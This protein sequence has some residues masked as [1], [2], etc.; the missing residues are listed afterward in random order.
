VFGRSRRL[1][2]FWN[3]FSNCFKPRLLLRAYAHD[4]MIQK[5]QT[6]FKSLTLLR[7]APAVLGI[8]FILSACAAQ[9]QR[10][11][12]PDFTLVDIKGNKFSLKDLR[13]KVVLLDFWA[14]WCPPCVIS[15]PEVEKISQ[16][17]KGKK[18]EV[19]RI[20]LD[21]SPDAVLRYLSTHSL[22]G[23]IAMTDGEVEQVYRVQGIPS[24]YMIDQTG[25][26]VKSWGGY[27]PMMPK[28][29]RQEID[30]LLN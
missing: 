8:F 12:A 19:V 7:L 29:W 14:T 23:R 3:A 5:S 2:P 6:L 18:F 25:G 24:F 11:S 10:Q 1:S 16:E 17:Y 26:L 28:I 22:T 27:H 9:A 30:R 13:G 21:D 4:V 15:S 20:S